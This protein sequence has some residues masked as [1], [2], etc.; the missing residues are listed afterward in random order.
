MPTFRNTVCSI[1]I[2]GWVYLLAYKDGIKC[3]ST[4]S[5]MKVEQT[6]CRDTYSGM[7]REQTVFRN[8]GILEGPAKKNKKAYYIQNTVEV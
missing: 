8:V 3:R 6:E 2:D 5:P 1:F 7:E 4:Y